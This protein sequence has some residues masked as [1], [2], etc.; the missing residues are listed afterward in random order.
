MFFMVQMNRQFKLKNMLLGKD[1]Y[2]A[3]IY[4]NVDYAFVVTIIV[5]LYEMFGGE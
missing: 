5:I 3:I 4:P 2:R 1:T